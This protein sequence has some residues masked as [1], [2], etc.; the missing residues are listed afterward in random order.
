MVTRY[1]V[2]QLMGATAA[3]AVKAAVRGAA[4]AGACVI[5]PL[6]IELFNIEDFKGAC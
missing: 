6:N 5:K 4:R 1:V 2:P 3:I